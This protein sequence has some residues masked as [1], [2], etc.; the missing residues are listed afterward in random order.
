[1]AKTVAY[2]LGAVTAIAG[3]WGIVLTPVLG[4][5]DA[6]MALS[7]GWLVTGLVLLAVA[8]WWEE[9]VA[10]ALIVLGVVYAIVAVLGLVMPGDVLGVFTNTA[11]DN[12]LHVVLAVVMLVVGFMVRGERAP[13]GQQQQAPM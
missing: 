3:I 5:F 10:W 13:A 7:V 12:W 1:M 8:L 2:V 9:S 6:N 11:S 4:I